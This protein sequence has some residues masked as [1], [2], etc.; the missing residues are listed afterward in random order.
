MSNRLLD[1]M[2]DWLRDEAKA[3][4]RK[5]SKTEDAYPNTPVLAAR[6]ALVAQAYRRAAVVLDDAAE[7]MG[8]EVAP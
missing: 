1:A 5:A 4:R 3:L 7:A 8:H 6:A 2:P